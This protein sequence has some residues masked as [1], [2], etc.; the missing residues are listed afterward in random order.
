MTTTAKAMTTARATAPTKA[1]AK[2][3]ADPYGMTNKRTSSVNDKVRRDDVCPGK[4][5][6][7]LGGLEGGLYGGVDFGLGELGGYA[8]AVH[9]GLLVGGAVANDADSADA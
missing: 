7:C 5:L 3:T 9:D 4:V 1:T 6:G 8:D 2:A